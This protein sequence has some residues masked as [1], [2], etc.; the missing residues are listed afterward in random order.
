MTKPHPEETPEQWAQRVLEEHGPMPQ[1]VV[2]HINRL[3]RKH[4]PETTQRKR[5]A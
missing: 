3:R 2:D 1:R 5:T 4:A